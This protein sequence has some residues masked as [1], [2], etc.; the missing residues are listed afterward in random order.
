LSSSLAQFSIA[1]I[2][3]MTVTMAVSMYF[4][5]E[6]EVSVKEC[7]KTCSPEGCSDKAL[8][9]LDGAVASYTGSL[10]GKDGSGHGKLL[11]DLADRECKEFK[12]CGT[13]GDSIKGTSKANLNI[14]LEFD[15][16]QHNLTARACPAALLHKD[17]ISRLMFI[18]LVQGTLRYAHML[19]YNKDVTEEDRAVGAAFAT[20]VAPMV[21]ACGY[22]DGQAIIDQ[23]AIDAEST[24][25]RKVKDLFEK[26][27]DCLEVKC[28]DIG[29]YWDNHKRKYHRDAEPCTFDPEEDH[30]SGLK[31]HHHFM[32]AFLLL[33]AAFGIYCYCCRGTSKRSRKSG[34]DDD[35]DDSIFSSSSYDSNFEFA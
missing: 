10:E 20:S 5:Q 16:M 32:I 7:M 2:K 33:S 12:T 35:D 22:Q 25:F 17:H 30:D 24:D 34:D 3:T 11:Y 19:S 8:K 13:H 21:A 1:A 23:M 18:P 27:Y 9:A 29:G 4:V 15:A 14:F 28:A 6:L 31:P 26:H